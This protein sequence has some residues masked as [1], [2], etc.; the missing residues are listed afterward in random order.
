MDDHPDRTSGLSESALCQ[1]AD[2]K[3]PRRQAWARAQL[4]R[5]ASTGEKYG[6]QDA[7]EAS[8]FA[9]LVRA[10]GYE[11][12]VIAWASVRDRLAP[13]RL[14]GR[15][16]LLYDLITKEALVVH[17]DA[18]VATFARRE[19]VMRLVH[20]GATIEDATGAFRRVS[21]ARRAGAKAAAG[22]TH[23]SP[24]QGDR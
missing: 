14:G 13:K 5:K 7:V 20:L 22:S 23:P 10:L 16:D 11:D 9:T 3:R 1:I 2:I 17:N 24:T 21:A 6:L 15:M 4:L 8:A 12:A 19:H 18:E